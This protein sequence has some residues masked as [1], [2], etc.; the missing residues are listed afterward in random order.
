VAA[1]RQPH[2]RLLTVELGH[3]LLDLRHG[4]GPDA[5]SAVEHPVDGGAAQPGLGR[6]VD[7]AVGAGGHGDPT[8]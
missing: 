2:L 1:P 3:R 5:G 7:D 8:S 6:D 4:R